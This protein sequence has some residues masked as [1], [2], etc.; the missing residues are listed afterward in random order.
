MAEV[1]LGLEVIPHVLHREMREDPGN[2][3][4]AVE[5]N[6]GWMAGSQNWN[7]KVG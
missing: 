3:F 4:L 7:E 5:S 1:A 6:A 2:V